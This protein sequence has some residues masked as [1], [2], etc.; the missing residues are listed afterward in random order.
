VLYI[1]VCI[2]YNARSVSV[3]SCYV[4]KLKI[5]IHI[6]KTPV[7][8]T[9]KQTKLQTYSVFFSDPYRACFAYFIVG[10]AKK[11]QVIVQYIKTL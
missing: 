1:R 7:L 4:K 5:H 9:P 11:F 3:I 2:L 10:N 8:H 6:E